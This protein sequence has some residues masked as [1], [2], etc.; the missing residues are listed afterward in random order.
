MSKRTTGIILNGATGRI[1]STQH[2]ANA[3]APIRD[4]GGL[5]H[6]GDRIVP[7][8]L[9]VGRDGA[10]LA[11]LAEH[12]GT[13]WTTDLDAALADP[14]YEIVCDTSV[15][16]HRTAVL[17]R[18]ITAGKHIYSEK[19]VA[20]SVAEGVQLLDAARRRCV[21][22]GA[23]E[24]KLYLPGL[25]KL[26][27]VVASG[28][29]GRIVGFRL[30]FGWWVFDG[31]EIPCQRP[32]WNYR[33]SEG[34]GLLF[35]MYPHWRYVIEGL[36]GPIDRLVAVAATATPERI[37]ER[38]ERYT[39]DVEDTAY[40]LLQMQSGAIG[41]ISSSWSTRVRRDDLLTVQIDGARGSAF[42][43]LHRCWTQHAG[44]MLR[45]PHVSVAKDAGIDYREGWT[46]VDAGA[47]FTNP[48]REGWEAFLKHVH[49]GTPMTADLSAGIRD[50]QIAE[51]CL[52]SI[53][54]GAWVG[55]EQV[56]P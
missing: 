20:L 54:D 16:H 26:S 42:A 43:G 49:A 13:S 39:V 5:A 52:R 3:L 25:R 6:G 50:V 8:V 41:T 44:Q 21:K 28:S 11:K 7:D 23:V 40:A 33:K 32:S 46:E 53:A 55:M 34:G 12:F 48:Y 4:E 29:L 24:D 47:T 19:P 51:A 18:A 15:T 17:H 22:H 9:L 31:F 1:G 27:R 38:G 2:L 14:R 30:E 56:A 36:L 45:T 10:K 37:D 35:D